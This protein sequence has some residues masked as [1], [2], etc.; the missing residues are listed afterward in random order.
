[1]FFYCSVGDHCQDGMVGV[2]NEGSDKLDSY[3]SAA[4]KAK[5]NVS[6]D[7]AFGGSDD[8][9]SMSSGMMS[10]TSMSESMGMT[11]TST[12]SM[13]MTGTESMTMTM[14]PT[15]AASTDPGSAA[16]TTTT[17]PGAAGHLTGPIV[18]V[19]GLALFMAGLLVL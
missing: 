8:S 15:D 3:M 4:A 18:A 19:G 9:S 14:M 7:A 11:M 16:P 17:E 13:T 10:S 1:M 12:E 6:P 5:E 2:I